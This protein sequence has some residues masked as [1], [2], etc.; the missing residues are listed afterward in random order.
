MKKI[1]SILS[2]LTLSLASFADDLKTADTLVSEYQQAEDKAIY[3]AENSES[4]GAIYNEQIAKIATAEEA[5]LNKPAELGKMIV[6]Y[7]NAIGLKDS[8]AYNFKTATIIY[9]NGIDGQYQWLKTNV[10]YAT[11]KADGYK[12]DGWS[13]FASNILKL[14]IAN[15][16]YDYL[17]TVDVSEIKSNYLMLYTNAMVKYIKTKSTKLEQYNAYVALWDSLDFDSEEARKA[18][19]RVAFS[20][21]EA[22]GDA[23]RGNKIK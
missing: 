16:D 12:I 10:D 1:I 8:D 2:I 6:A 14:A 23:V 7:A 15:N 18:Q 21:D 22:Y 13:L 9:G 5:W 19:A 11:L 20:K 3:M 17:A 4:I